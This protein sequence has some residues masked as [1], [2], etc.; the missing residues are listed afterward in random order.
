MKLLQDAGLAAR[1]FDANAILERDLD[2]A[3]TA[4][5]SQRAKLAQLVSNYDPA[6]RVI[7]PPDEDPIEY[8][9]SD[10]AITPTAGT[11]KSNHTRS[12]QVCFGHIGSGIRRVVKHTAH[13][14][15]TVRSFNDS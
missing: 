7:K 12:S 15:M 8:D 9:S 4:D 5:R 14:T 6:T 11:Q 2:E 1:S 13:V 10:R 3:I